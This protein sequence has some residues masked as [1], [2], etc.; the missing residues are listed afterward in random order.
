MNADP[1]SFASGAKLV[2]LP[3]GFKVPAMRAA[4]KSARGKRAQAVANH[5]S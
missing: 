1:W 2:L 3:A 4:A 5:V